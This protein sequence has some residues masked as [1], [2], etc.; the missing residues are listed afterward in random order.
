MLCWR[1][2]LLLVRL[3]HS[4]SLCEFRLVKVFVAE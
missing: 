2:A 4:L 1:K 3:P